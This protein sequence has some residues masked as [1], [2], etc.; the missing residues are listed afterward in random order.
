MS[1]E[2][3]YCQASCEGKRQLTKVAAERSARW[4]RRKDWGVVVAY[5]CTFCRR[6]HIGERSDG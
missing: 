3:R 5:R 4:M 1:P 6:W 2:Q